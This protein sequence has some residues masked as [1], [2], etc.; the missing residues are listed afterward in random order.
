MLK[1]KN[2]KQNIYSNALKKQKG[3][4]SKAE[5]NTLGLN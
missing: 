4:D 1:Y 2:W 3:E 5:V